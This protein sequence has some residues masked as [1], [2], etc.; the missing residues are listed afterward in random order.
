MT[1]GTSLGRLVAVSCVAMS[2]VALSCRELQCRPKVGFNNREV[3]GNE[4]SERLR[5]R[6]RVEMC[7]REWK[8]CRC[9]CR[10]RSDF[11]FPRTSL[12]S[13]YGKQYLQDVIVQMNM[14]EEMGHENKRFC[15]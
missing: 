3:L 4:K 5:Q 2:C 8:D 12:L 7:A 13:D 10:R 14:Q 15:C 9:R 11:L 6:E 1:C